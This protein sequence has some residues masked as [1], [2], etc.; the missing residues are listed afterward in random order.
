ML[1][2][3]HGDDDVCCLWFARGPAQAEG[4]EGDGRDGDGG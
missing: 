3:G 1:A 2:P 4:D